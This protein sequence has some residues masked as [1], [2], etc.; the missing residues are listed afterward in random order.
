MKTDRARE[1]VVSVYE[2]GVDEIHGFRGYRGKYIDQALASLYE[3]V[4]KKE[5]KP[6]T[7]MS[8]SLKLF[9]AGYNQAVDEIADLFKTAER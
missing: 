4:M 1:I 3:M 8:D 2:H 6:F 7:N 5:R 9:R